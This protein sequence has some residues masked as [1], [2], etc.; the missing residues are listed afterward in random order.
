MASPS[1]R[2][3]KLNG[4]VP[5][6]TAE[7]ET[8]SPEHTVVSASGDAVVGWFTMSEAWLVTALHAP[9]TTTEYS[10]A[11]F[12]VTLSKESVAFVSFISTAPFFRQ[13]MLNG[14]APSGV[15]VKLTGS[16]TQRVAFESALAVV[17]WSKVSVAVLVAALQRPA[18]STA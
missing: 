16:P 9:V 13:T 1:F 2:Q 8:S 18:T 5:C 17:F 15:V 3:T 6:G 4:P 12:V 11:S 10:P 7:N 14:P